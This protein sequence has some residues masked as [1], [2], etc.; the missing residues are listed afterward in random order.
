MPVGTVRHLLPFR[1]WSKR[2]ELTVRPSG[3]PW[4]VG[5]CPRLCRLVTC[6]QDRQHIIAVHC[7]YVS[8]YGAPA[9]RLE[10]PQQ[11]T[12]QNFRI[13][14]RRGP[15]ANA[16]ATRSGGLLSHGYGQGQAGAVE[17]ARAQHRG[18]RKQTRE[19]LDIDV[20]PRYA[21]AGRQ[22]PANVAG[23][24]SRCSYPGSAPVL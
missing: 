18:R 14:G 1:S 15:P 6:W 23:S 21:L 11:L 9:V 24:E 17:S 16:A 20:Q 22:V 8:S 2:F 10:H 3:S 19:V 5:R 7:K 12:R 4:R 13:G